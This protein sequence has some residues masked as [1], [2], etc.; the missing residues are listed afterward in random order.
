LWTLLHCSTQAGQ[1]AFVYGAGRPKAHNQSDAPSGDKVTEQAGGVFSNE[2]IA[3]GTWYLVATCRARHAL[4]CV[5]IAV[6]LPSASSSD[7]LL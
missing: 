2:G 3:F 1:D 7:G 4:I 6:R 5:G